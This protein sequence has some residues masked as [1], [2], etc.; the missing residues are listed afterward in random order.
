MPI[1][2]LEDLSK[3]INNSFTAL[4]EHALEEMAEEDPDALG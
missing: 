1:E 2:Y 3:T 4:I